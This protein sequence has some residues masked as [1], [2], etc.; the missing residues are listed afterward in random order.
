MV[1]RL[2]PRNIVFDSID[3]SNLSQGIYSLIL[4]D[5]KKST[6]KKIVVK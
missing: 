2:F 6:I 3:I 4:S 5:G 1:E